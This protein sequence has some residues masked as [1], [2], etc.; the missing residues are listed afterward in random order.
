MRFTYIK[1][2]LKSVLKKLEN[3]K[4]VDNAP[5]KVVALEL[6][7]KQ[8]AEKRINALTEKLENLRAQS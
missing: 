5:E 4:F 1:G 3:K 6:K 8:D 7:K 2:F